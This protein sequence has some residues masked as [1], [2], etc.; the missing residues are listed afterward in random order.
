MSFDY[1]KL[2]EVPDSG[3]TQP[4]LKRMRTRYCFAR[5]YC[6]GKDVLEVACGAGM[7]LGL[8]AGCAKTVVAGDF[9][10]A[11]LSKA[12]GH[13]RE[14]VP[15]VRFDAHYMPFKDSS[16]DVLILYEAIYYLQKPESFISECARV[17]RPGGYVLVC[18]PN[19]SLPDFHPS[20]HSHEY[21]TASELSVIF[22]KHGFESS[23]F[24]NECVSNSSLGSRAITAL[25]KAAVKLNLIPGTLKSREFLKRLFFGPLA[26]IPAEL[27]AGEFDMPVPI[28]GSSHAFRVIYAVARKRQ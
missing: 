12:G 9:T 25:K 24:G 27:E 22:T 3:A 6:K 26:V 17:L 11:L 19:K 2:T 21:F 23:F 14:R 8:L 28:N 16:F 7:G 20:P 5:E 10:M 4:Q 13:Y 18:L 1:S 15:L